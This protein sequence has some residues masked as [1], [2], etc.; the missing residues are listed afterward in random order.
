VLALAVLLGLAMGGAGAR[1]V[2]PAPGGARLVP[3]AES[4]PLVVVGAV[5][6]AAPL[7]DHGWAAR[8]EVEDVLVARAGARVAP[9]QSLRVA[10]EELARG[11]PPRIQDDGRA[12]LAL[13][14][15]PADSIWRQRLPGA[16]A[17]ALAEEGD[18]FLRDPD[19]ATLEALRGWAELPAEE[20]EREPGVAAL[21]RLAAVAAPSVAEGALERLGRIP[22]LADRID[23]PAR[24]GLELALSSRR[25]LPLRRRLVALA[26]ARGL[27]ALRTAL[28]S[29]AAAEDELAADA[30]AALAKLPGGLGDERVQAL[31]GHDEAA[32]RGVAAS[33]A[34]GPET[35][36]R[37]ARMLRTDPAPE[38]RAR[39]V[40]RLLAVRDEAAF[41][42][43]APALWDPSPRV[44]AAAAGAVAD[45]GPVL[46]PQLEA[47][48]R[49]RR[50][51]ETSGILGA[52]VLS[53]ARGRRSVE[54]L[55][56]TH[57]DPATRSL[58][59][60]ALGR[61]PDAH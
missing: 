34:T 49:A 29:A 4:A 58:A 24:Q 51:P 60:L 41:E 13:T 36:D 1:A 19:G 31:L 47:L 6:R 15:L 16:R 18:A 56:E 5:E 8:F 12:I 46:V 23:A 2:P 53:G 43:A 27:E 35:L 21:A 44:R 22:G 55:A 30:L 45:V 7:D 26:G 37:L 20:R 40:E 9:G 48:A 42:A 17:W 38:V 28:E 54:Q 59:R 11:R 52:L 57:P 14:P 32:L 33:A 3:A 50:M 25:P 39:A 61:G 10:W